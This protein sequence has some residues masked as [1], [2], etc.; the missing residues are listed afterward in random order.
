MVNLY[1]ENSSKNDSVSNALLNEYKG[2][3]FEYLV[4]AHLAA[5]WKIEK[6]FLLSFGGEAK[7]RL[8]FYQNEL[9]KAD[10]DL[11]HQ[12]GPSALKAAHLIDHYY[13]QL[14]FHNILVLGKSA[15]GSH[16]ES[17]AECDIMLCSDLEDIPVS[18]KFCK[19]GAYVNTKSAGIRSFITK[20]FKAFPKAV[21][22]QEELNHFLDLSFES[23]GR[24]MYDKCDLVYDNFGDHW[25][26]SDLPGELPSHLKEIL[27]NHYYNVCSKLFTTIK[28][29]Y[30]SD[31]EM[32][33][34]SLLPIIGI[35]RDDI[36]QVTCFHKN[37][38]HIESIEFF[39]KKD[40]VALK[41]SLAFLD[42]KKETSSF[43]ISLKDKILQIRVK[44]MN[45]FTVSGLKVNCSLKYCNA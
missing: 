34:D 24:A 28:E 14:S 29:F 9:L 44:P 42:Y 45:V 19:K 27:L 1:K 43:E 38:H 6:P 2:N 21:L 33:F 36:V 7:K 31:P 25:N 4:A 12:L 16:D 37:G 13:G 17:F 20:Y 41:S 35:G 32:F 15:G 10:P 8:T 22:F 40:F 18:L 23:M 11:Y 30:K 26:E 39:D 3:L 5:L